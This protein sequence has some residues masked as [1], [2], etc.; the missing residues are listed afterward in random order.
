MTVHQC[1]VFHAEMHCYK[2]VWYS[3]R[4]PVSTHDF[5]DASS[6]EV[7]RLQRGPQGRVQR[8]AAAAGAT[9][10]KRGAGRALEDGSGKGG[11]PKASRE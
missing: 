3:I 5:G 7:W 9:G 6:C 1:N 4:P 8:T 2:T 10:R 11:E